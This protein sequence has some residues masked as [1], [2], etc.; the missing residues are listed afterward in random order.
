MKF[1]RRPDGRTIGK[2]GEFFVDRREIFPPEP[3]KTDAANQEE[4]ERDGH[5][6]P[7]VGE[8]LHG[9]EEKTDLPHQGAGYGGD[10]K[11][12]LPAPTGLV[13]FR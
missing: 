8:G 9:K 10:V 2:V 1:F 6:V 4:G 12:V 3:I 5:A 7:I 11:A 13:L